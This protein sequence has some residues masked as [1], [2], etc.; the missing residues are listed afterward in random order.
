VLIARKRPDGIPFRALPFLLCALAAAPDSGA[1]EREPEAKVLA[2]GRAALERGLAEEAL[3][4]YLR[5][6]DAHPA[7]AA[8]HHEAA[9]ALLDLD[10]PE[11]ASRHLQAALDLLPGHVPSLVALA[12][13][14]SGEGRLEEAARLLARAIEVDPRSAAARHDLAVVEARRGNLDAAVA[15]FRRAAELAPGECKVKYGLGSALEK[16]GKLEEA[17]AELEAA[18]AL[19]PS[20]PP[21]RYRLATVLLRLGRR[22][23]GEREM[24]RFREAKAAL[25]AHRGEALARRKDFT[26]AARE[27]QRAVDALPDHAASHGRLGSLCLEIRDPA[28]ALVHARRAAELDPSALRFANLSWAAKESGDLQESLRWIQKAIEMEPERKDFIE[29]RA[30]ILEAL[31]R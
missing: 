24:K 8:L 22:E 13:V 17:R 6:L 5:G 12:L 30:A 1:E 23:D 7:S 14:R 4:L 21:P 25:H 16:M 2:A 29:Q 31:S 18:C 28:R 11:T 3:A 20:F 15:E 27:Y 9:R 26:G 19:D 10:Q